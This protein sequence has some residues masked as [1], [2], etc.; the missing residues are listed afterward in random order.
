MDF[1]KRLRA[2]REARSLSQEELAQLVLSSPD[3]IARF[4]RGSEPKA[5]TLAELSRVLGVSADHLL[6]LTEAPPAQ[7]P[8]D[9]RSDLTPDMRRLLKTA[10]KLGTR[11]LNLVA[12]LA[13]A[14]LARQVA[15]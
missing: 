15:P 9:E 12:Q 10:R 11:E 4:E 1:S 7:V 3:T 14:L 6:G 13:D 8:A 2:A 5:S